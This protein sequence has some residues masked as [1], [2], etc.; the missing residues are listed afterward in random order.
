LAE[1]PEDLGMAFYQQEIEVIGSVGAKNEIQISIDAG[2][3]YLKTIDSS[4]N[5]HSAFSLRHQVFCLELAGKSGNPEGLD[6]DSFDDVARHLAIFDRRTDQLIATCR[7]ICS[8]F[9]ERF[10]S[11]G[12]FDCSALLSR[13]E[14]KLEIGR[15]CVDRDF[16]NS[17]IVALLWR[18]IAAYIEK[19]GAEI[20][21]GCG[22]VP[23]LD[24]LE[25]ANIYRYLIENK[26]VKFDHLIHPKAKYQSRALSEILAR[27][28]SPLTDEEKTRVLASVPSLCRSYFD[29]GCY[30]AGPP[31]FDYDLKC[32]DFLTILEVPEMSSKVRRRLFRARYA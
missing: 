16:R 23:T 24:P 27:E 21:F 17:I 11:E 30:V 9:S 4:A 32:V 14:V 6:R 7:L 8:R 26:K 31:A 22:S 29:I 15:V 5:L 19:S 10:Y 28:R 2:R 3:F 20:L 12:E 25:A 1:K 18:G 13:P